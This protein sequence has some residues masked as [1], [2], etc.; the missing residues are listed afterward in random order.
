MVAQGAGQSGYGRVGIATEVAKD[1]GGRGTQGPIGIRQFVDQ[2]GNG[3]GTGCSEGVGSVE[4]GGIAALD[5]GRV[6]GLV[7]FRSGERL[8]AQGVDQRRDGARAEVA[9]GVG[10]VEARGFGGGL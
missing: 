10:G 4:V 1:V 9:E 8:R 2:G 6:A 3:G 7:G 5:I